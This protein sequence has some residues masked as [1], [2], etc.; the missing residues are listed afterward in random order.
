MSLIDPIRAFLEIGA[1]AAYGLY[2]EVLQQVS[3]PA[4]AALRGVSA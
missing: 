4:L 2:G 3:L 1:M